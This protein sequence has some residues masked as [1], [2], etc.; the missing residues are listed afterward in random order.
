[1]SE[2]LSWRHVLLAAAPLVLASACKPNLGSPPSIVDDLEPRILAVR[3]V[4]AEAAENTPVTY[5][6]LAANSDGRVAMPNVAWSQCDERKPPA[7][8]NAV[9]AACLAPDTV[10]TAAPTFQA[11][12]PDGACKR[13]G[14][15][16]DV[17]KNMVPLRPNDP[18]ATGGFYQPVRARLAAGGGESIAFALERIKCRLT[19]ASPDATGKFNDLYKLNQNPTIAG[20][21]LDPDGAPVSLFSRATGA[22]APPPPTAPSTWVAARSPYELELTW[23]ADSLESFPVWN[24]G[25]QTVDLHREAIS[26]SWY[27]TSGTFEH[28]RTGHAETEPDVTTR[29]RWTAPVTMTTVNVHFWIV[30]RDSRGGIDFAEALVEVRP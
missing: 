26:V 20:F 10:E 11:D 15:Q 18:D 24:I 16:S 1:M 13:F 19:N 9:A 21:T 28:D 7:E 8:G 17:D 2:R 25:A 30:L 23:T 4:P 14:P 22:A 3:G 29:N 6:V 27:A 5:D 12:M